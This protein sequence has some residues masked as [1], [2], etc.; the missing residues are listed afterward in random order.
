MQQQLEALLF[1]GFKLDLQQLLQTA[2]RFLRAN[3]PCFI[4]QETSP[5]SIAGIFS[6]RVLAAAGGASAAEL[7][8]RSCLQEQLG[9]GFGVGSVFGDVEY[10]TTSAYDELSFTATLLR[11]LY[12]FS[13]GTRVDVTFDARGYVYIRRDGDEFSA[14]SKYQFGVAIGPEHSFTC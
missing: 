11:D 10:D 3:A 13:K 1:V 14:D 12:E 5:G 6:P 7:L 4:E 2:L 8:S 9:L